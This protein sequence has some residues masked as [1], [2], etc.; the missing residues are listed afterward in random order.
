MAKT[1][2]GRIEREGNFQ[3]AAQLHLS[4]LEHNFAYGCLEVALTALGARF[5]LADVDRCGQEATPTIEIIENAGF[6]INWQVRPEAEISATDLEPLLTGKIQLD[7]NF[8][9]G[10]TCGFLLSTHFSDGSGHAIAIVAKENAKYDVFDTAGIGRIELEAANI[11]HLI[12][13]TQRQGGEC[14]LCQLTRP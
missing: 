12:N 3:A 10:L 11:A 13:F 7:E 6:R 5:T 1:E 2:L 14:W 8:P 9:E 4:L